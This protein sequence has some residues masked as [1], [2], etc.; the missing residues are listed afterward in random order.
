MKRET[1]KLLNQIDAV[2]RELDAHTDY[3]FQQRPFLE[4]GGEPEI[5]EK[6]QEQIDQEAKLQAMLEIGNQTNIFQEIV[7]TQPVFNGL[8]EQLP[9]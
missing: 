2:V 5:K 8:G 7:K 9:F 1:K 6:S 3:F 4:N